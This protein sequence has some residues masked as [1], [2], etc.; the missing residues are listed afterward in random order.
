MTDALAD[1]LA[2]EGEIALALLMA[3][4]SGPRMG[5]PNVTPARWRSRR[6]WSR[7]LFACTS[8]TTGFRATRDGSETARILENA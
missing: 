4:F 8:H 7:P 6:E 3:L 5:P 1:I 2:L